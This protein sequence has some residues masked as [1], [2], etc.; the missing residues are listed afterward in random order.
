MLLL[1]LTTG[2]DFPVLP[3]QVTMTAKAANAVLERGRQCKVTEKS[4][5]AK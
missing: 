3:A 5:S 2:P 1:P 4:S